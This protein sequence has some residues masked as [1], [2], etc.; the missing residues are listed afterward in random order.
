LLQGDSGG[1]LTVQDNGENILIGA[2]S[3]VEST[4]NLAYP[5]GYAKL[6]AVRNWIDSIIN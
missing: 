5:C 1:P 2:A 6:S 4:C 3:W